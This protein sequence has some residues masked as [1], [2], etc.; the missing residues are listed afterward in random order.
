LAEISYE[1]L[2]TVRNQQPID[3]QIK[4]RKWNWTGHTSRKP[5]KAIKKTALDWNSQSAHRS[6]HP[7]KTWGKLEKQ[8]KHGTK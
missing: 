8:A 4:K 3:V 5:T 7:R 6:G 2:W 1:N